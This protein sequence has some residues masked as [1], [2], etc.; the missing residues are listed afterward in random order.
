MSRRVPFRWTSAPPTCAKTCNSTQTRCTFSFN[1]TLLLSCQFLEFPCSEDRNFKI[2]KQMLNNYDPK[3]KKSNCCCSR[4]LKF[5]IKNFKR[6]MKSSK[7]KISTKK[8]PRSGS[9]TFT[10]NLKI[11]SERLPKN[12]LLGT[13]C[14]PKCIKF[15]I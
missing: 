12:L 11:A 2:V 8:M 6:K 14:A 13:L 9:L 7:F 3:F 1:S 15:G 5:Q 10:T 4:I